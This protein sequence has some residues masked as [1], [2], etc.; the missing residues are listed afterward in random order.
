MIESKFLN[1]ISCLF[2][3]NRCDAHIEQAMENCVSDIA[4]TICENIEKQ[5]EEK[6]S[7][8]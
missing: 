4:G 5:F 8:I 6:F 7:Q 3:K 1:S 2:E